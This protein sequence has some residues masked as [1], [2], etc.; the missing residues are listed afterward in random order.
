MKFG[1]PVLVER[2]GGNPKGTPGSRRFVRGILVG[3]RGNELL[4]RLTEDDPLDTVGWNKKGMVGRWSRSAVKER[5][6]R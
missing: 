6:D 1:T 2:G 3:A 5:E 4:V